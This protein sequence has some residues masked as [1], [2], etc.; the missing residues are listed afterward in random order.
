MCLQEVLSRRAYVLNPGIQHLLI[1]ADRAAWAP[2]N[3]G[4]GSCLF[5][6]FARAWLLSACIVWHVLLVVFADKRI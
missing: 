4:A 6:N 1:P 5:G 3:H 2:A